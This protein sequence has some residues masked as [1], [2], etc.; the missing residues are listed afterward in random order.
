M[1]LAIDPKIRIRQDAVATVAW[2]GLLGTGTWTSRS[3]DQ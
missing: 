1:T 2:G 3:Q